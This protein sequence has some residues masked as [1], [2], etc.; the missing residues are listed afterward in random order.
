MLMKKLVAA[1]FALHAFAAFAA[2]DVNKADQAALESVKGI[3]PGLSAK[4]LAERKKAAFKDWP[5]LIERVG[6]VGPGNAQRFS[7]A[8]LTVNDAPYSAAAKADK[9]LAAKAKPA[10]KP[11]K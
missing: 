10:D 7:T 3:G 2:V 9:P 5:D 1:L 6:G 8:G 4:L 11:A